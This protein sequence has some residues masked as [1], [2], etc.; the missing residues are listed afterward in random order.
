MC[1]CSVSERG[2]GEQCCAV[3]TEPPTGNQRTNALSMSYLGASNNSCI[4]ASRKQIQLSIERRWDC[5]HVA[6]PS[7]NAIAVADILVYVFIFSVGSI[8]T[9]KV[10]VHTAY[11]SIGATHSVTTRLA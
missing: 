4:I 11:G 6:S 10:V 9:V 3:E 1:A 8:Y 2:G 7:A 5:A